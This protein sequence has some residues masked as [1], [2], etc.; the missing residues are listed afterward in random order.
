V[1]RCGC[2]KRKLVRDGLASK[3]VEEGRRVC[4]ASPG[5]AVRLLAEKVVEEALELADNP[6]PE[7]AAD[8]LEALAELAERAG[9]G[10]DGVLREAGRKRR[11]RGGFSGLWV[12]CLDDS[13]N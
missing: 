5:E 1:E 8:V 3:L 4:R 10:W 11:E 2:G 6:S 9:W 7:E 13:D 12:L